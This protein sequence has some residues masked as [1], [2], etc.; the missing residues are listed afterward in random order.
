MVE[1]EPFIKSQIASRGYLQGLMRSKFGHVTPQIL[2][3]TKPCNKFP[4]QNHWERA[5]LGTSIRN[6]PLLGPCGRTLPRVLW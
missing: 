2:A 5:Y 6:T 1:Y 4:G 3:P